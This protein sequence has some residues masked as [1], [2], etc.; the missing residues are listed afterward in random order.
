M[1]RHQI[2]CKVAE[3]AGK[4]MQNAE[5]Y[6]TESQQDGKTRGG[7]GEPTPQPRRGTRRSHSPDRQ[8]LSNPPGRTIPGSTAGWNL[9]VPCPYRL[10]KNPHFRVDRAGSAKQFST[11]N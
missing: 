7:S 5:A 1:T 6:T 4:E 11:R 2:K 3:G 10:W 9:S 8:G